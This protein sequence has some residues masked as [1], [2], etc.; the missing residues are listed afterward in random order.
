M[1]QL[2]LLRHAKSSWDSSAN[3]D[4]ERPLNPRGRRAAPRMGRLCRELDLLP[5]LMLSSDSARTMETVKLFTTAC[6]TEI[7]T[8]FLPELY[9]ASPS[10]LLD[11]ASSA[12]R[13]RR[14]ML[15]AHNPGL[16]ELVERLSGE[17][18]RF[19]TGSLALL[20]STSNSGTPRPPRKTVASTGSGGPR[21]WTTDHPPPLADTPR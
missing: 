15:V 21:S 5:D 8:R 17:S 20:I 14:L 3:S 16:E 18:H 11:A 2:L 13:S 9:H 1:F 6:E 12:G 10:R 4:H 19:P 7:E